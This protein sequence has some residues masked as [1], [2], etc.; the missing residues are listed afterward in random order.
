MLKKRSFMLCKKSCSYA[1]SQVSIC[2]R[3]MLSCDV[4]C[5]HE[6]FKAAQLFNPE[7]VTNFKPTAVTVD[8]LKA[9]LFFGIG[10]SRLKSEL[11]TYRLILFN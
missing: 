11:P 8:Q 1:T 10:L 5:R 6:A 2:Y 4:P 7:K 9:F 3:V